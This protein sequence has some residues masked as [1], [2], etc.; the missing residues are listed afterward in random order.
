MK[1]N[2]EILTIRLYWKVCNILRK[3]PVWK[4][5][6]DILSWRQGCGSSSLSCGSNR[7][8]HFDTDP[9]PAFQFNADP[10]PQPCFKEPL[11]MSAIRD[12]YLGLDLTIQGRSI[13]LSI[14]WPSPFNGKHAM[15]FYFLG[16]VCEAESNAA[17]PQ[18]CGSGGSLGQKASVSAS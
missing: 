3:V 18:P 13:T 16:R 11:K 7:A 1:P 10:D 14:W 2:V 4:A 12:P 17:L 15:L 6:F 8:F 9:D 5:G